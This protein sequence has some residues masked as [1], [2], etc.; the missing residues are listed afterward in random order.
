MYMLSYMFLKPRNGKLSLTYVAKQ[1]QGLEINIQVSVSILIV[2]IL[3]LSLGK[4]KIRGPV[5]QGYE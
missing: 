1:A 4:Y 2:S 5:E 3:D